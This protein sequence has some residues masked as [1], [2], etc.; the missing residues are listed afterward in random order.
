[1]SSAHDENADE[2][3]HPEADADALFLGRKFRGQFLVVEAEIG[4]L[5]RDVLNN[6]RV[7]LDCP[8]LLWEE[9]RATAQLD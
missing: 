4:V 8:R 1:M 7:V 3:P 5:G 2:E 9:S 6:V